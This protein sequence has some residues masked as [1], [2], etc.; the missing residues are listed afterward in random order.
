MKKLEDLGSKWLATKILDHE[1]HKKMIKQIFQRVDE[2]MK[3]FNVSA[4]LISN[5][6]YLYIFV[7]R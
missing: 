1:E 5:Y 2:G 7:T 4:I 6:I 3:T